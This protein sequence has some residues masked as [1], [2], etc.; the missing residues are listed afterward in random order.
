MPKPQEKLSPKEKNCKCFMPVLNG[1]EGVKNGVFYCMFCSAYCMHCT[2]NS[3][4][5][6]SVF[7]ESLS[8]SLSNSTSSLILITVFSFFTGLNLFIK[9]SSLLI[10]F[11]VE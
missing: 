7:A 9:Y 8:T 1:L 2:I 6:M 5:L 11:K 3:L 4:R 10:V